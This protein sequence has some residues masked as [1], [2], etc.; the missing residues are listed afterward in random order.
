MKCWARSKSCR[1]RSGLGHCDRANASSAAS[2]SGPARK[3]RSQAS[4]CGKHNLG[5]IGE[6]LATGARTVNSTR[7]AGHGSG[8]ANRDLKDGWR[9]K[10]CCHRAGCSYRECARRGSRA[11]SA[12]AGKREAA[13]GLCCERHLRVLCE[14][15]TA[16]SST[17]NACRAA[18]HRSRACQ[19]NRN[20]KRSRGAA[21]TA[22]RATPAAGG[23]IHG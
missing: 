7:I 1:H 3:C 12:P 18:G 15:G 2:S 6:A 21:R 8:P 14:A 13:A 20:W 5:V 10:G 11:C 16:G 19:R 23:K 22:R 9:L 17:G 4:R